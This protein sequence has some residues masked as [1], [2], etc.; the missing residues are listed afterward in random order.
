VIIRDWRGEYYSNP[1]LAGAPVLVRNDVAIS[2][3]WGYNAPASGLPA[4]NFSARWSRSLN[5]PGGLY[6]IYIQADDGV[7]LWVDGRLIIDEWH[8]SSPVTYVDDVRFDPGRHDFRIEYYERSGG[9]QIDLYWQRLN[10]T[11]QAPQAIAGG[12]YIV[13]EGSSISLDGSRSKDPDGYLNR[14]EWDFNYDGRT[15]TT[16][17]TGK[18]PPVSY[19]DGPANYTV[20]LRVIDDRGAVSAVATTWI[21][22]E[23]VAPG[24]EAGGP[25]SGQPGQAIR[26]AGTAADASPTDQGSLSYRWDFGD[27]TT[28]NGPVIDHTY[29]QAGNYTARLTVFDKDGA[30]GT[31]T[32]TVQVRGANQTPLAVIKGPGGGRTGENLSFSGSESRDPDGN[33]VSYTWNFGDGTTANGVNVSHSY[34]QP[35]DYHLT[36]TVVDNGG[37]IGSSGM[38]VHIDWAAREPLAKISGS[39]GG[40]VGTP[41]NFSGSD[42]SD[43]DGSIVSYTWDFG[44]GTTGSGVD[45]SHTYTAYGTYQVTLTVTDNDGLTG[46][47]TRTV[48]IDE[49]IQIELPPTAVMNAPGSGSV[50]QNLVFDASDS[51]DSDGTIVAYTWDFGD[52]A[53][54]S[55]PTPTSSHSYA[56][57]GVYTVTLIVVDDDGLS[58]TA[59]Q[60]VTITQP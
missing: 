12:P 29:V 26:F 45:V 9:A 3:N 42:S 30:Q 59:T 20:A 51:S 16:D 47:T 54:E 10:D 4:D 21:T 18:Y 39:T 27:G 50:N 34:S 13:R 35:G 60:T 32:A 33:I 5:M 43:P 57:P 41:L 22:V 55:G 24:V 36:L 19:P 56:E 40:L 6:R 2:F 23:N 58:N 28:A 44:D 38:N 14:Y 48:T 17:A 49:I 8:D 11:N 31:D 1:T 46:Q 25:Y 15:F 37:A 52:G 7:R 53:V